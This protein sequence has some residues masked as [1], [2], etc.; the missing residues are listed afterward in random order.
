MTTPK[1]HYLWIYVMW[2]QD[3]QRENTDAPESEQQEVFQFFTMK[4]VIGY[5]EGPS[6]I[7]TLCSRCCQQSQVFHFLSVNHKLSVASVYV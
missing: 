3:E 7:T 1:L 5:S 4:S 2:V 6:I